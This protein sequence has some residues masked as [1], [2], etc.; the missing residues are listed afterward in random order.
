MNAI[1][2]RSAKV[3]WVGLIGKCHGITSTAACGSARRSSVASTSEWVMTA[4]QEEAAMNS[5]A[6]T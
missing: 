2:L 5:S 1:P 6:R 4:W 3:A